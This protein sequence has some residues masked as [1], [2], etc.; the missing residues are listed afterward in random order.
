MQHFE[1]ATPNELWRIDYKVYFK[2]DQGRCHTLTILD[3]HSRFLL[4]LHPCPNQL[5]Q[6]V[7]TQLTHTFRNYNLSIRMLMD[8]GFPWGDDRQSPHTI[9]TV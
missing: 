7:Q 1:R 8:N 4:G 3:D 5:W 6:T 2:L 9:L